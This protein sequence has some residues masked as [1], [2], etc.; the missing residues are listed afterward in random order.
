[1]CKGY[2]RGQEPVHGGGRE[3]DTMAGQAVQN[4][5]RSDFL[6]NREHPESTDIGKTYSKCP[7]QRA[8]ME[9]YP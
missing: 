3:W 7:G 4:T 8:S 6:F 9:C 5:Y 2:L 1:M